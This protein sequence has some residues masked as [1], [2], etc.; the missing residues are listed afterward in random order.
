VEGYSNVK[1]DWTGLPNIPVW[2]Q[3]ILGDLGKADPQELAEF[4]FPS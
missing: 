1:L 3:R 2:V 4:P